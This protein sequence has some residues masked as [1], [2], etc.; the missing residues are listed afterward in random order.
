MSALPGTTRRYCIANYLK[1]K[2]ET[3]RGGSSSIERGVTVQCKPTMYHE[4]L[5]HHKRYIVGCEAARRDG[6]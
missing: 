5:K 6:S 1:L 3:V 2:E 4:K